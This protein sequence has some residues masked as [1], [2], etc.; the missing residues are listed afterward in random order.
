[1]EEARRPRRVSRRPNFRRQR[2]QAIL[3][4]MLI[5]LIAVAFLRVVFFNKSFG[6]KAML[7]KTML[8]L[9]SHLENYLKTGTKSGGSG[10][11]SLDAFAGTNQWNN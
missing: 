2:G 8:R 1:M 4:F 11:K 10:V 7:D 9:G 3:E 6:F 5:L